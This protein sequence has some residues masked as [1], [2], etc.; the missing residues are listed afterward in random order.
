MFSFAKTTG[1]EKVDRRSMNYPREE[2]GKMNDPRE[3]IGMQFR[4]CYSAWQKVFN[5][6]CHK[7]FPFLSCSAWKLYQ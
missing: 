1:A 3:E 4:L 6:F 2:T 5:T 7:M